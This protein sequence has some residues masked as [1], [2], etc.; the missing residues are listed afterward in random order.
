MLSWGT[1]EEGRLFHFGRDGAKRGQ[2]RDIIVLKSM[3]MD[4]MS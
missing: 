3:S 2:S 4:E 1:D